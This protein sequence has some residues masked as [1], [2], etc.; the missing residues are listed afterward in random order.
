MLHLKQQQK[1]PRWGEDLEHPLKE[2]VSIDIIYK[3]FS[4]F[5]RWFFSPST[6]DSCQ[7][8]LTKMT[9]TSPYYPK[10]YLADGKGCQWVITAPEGHIVALEFEEFNVSFKKSITMYLQRN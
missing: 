3:H 9:L 5:I 2:L 4:F 6:D 10:W 8:W 7:Y 1:L